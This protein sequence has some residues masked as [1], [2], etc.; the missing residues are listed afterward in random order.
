MLLSQK[1]WQMMKCSLDET[2]VAQGNH[3]AFFK[4]TVCKGVQRFVLSK[5]IAILLSVICHTSNRCWPSDSLGRFIPF[6]QH[7]YE[8]ILVASGFHL[9]NGKLSSIETDYLWGH[10]DIVLHHNNTAFLKQL[11]SSSFPYCILYHHLFVYL[12]TALPQ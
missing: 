8:F 5:G 2:A 6:H 3:Y 9:C 11:V 1:Y 4:Q 12:Y 7:F 10:S